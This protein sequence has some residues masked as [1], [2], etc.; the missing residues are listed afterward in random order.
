MLAAVCVSIKDCIEINSIETGYLRKAVR[1]ICINIWEVQFCGHILTAAC[2]LTVS[3][4]FFSVLR[5]I[6]TSVLRMQGLCG[7]Y[8]FLPQV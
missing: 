1:K 8:P 7:C 4:P 5:K 3:M 2:V 6:W